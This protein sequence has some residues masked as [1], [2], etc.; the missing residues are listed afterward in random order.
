MLWAH[1]FIGRFDLTVPL[2]TV[3]VGAAAVVAASFGLIYLVP[4]RPEKPEQPGPRLPRWVVMALQAIALL[5]LAFLVVVGLL[6]RQTTVLNAATILFWVVTIPLLPIA[7]CLVGG[8]YQVANPFALLAR[9]LTGGA[10]ARRDPDPRVARWGYWPAV[11]QMF[12]LVFFELALRPVPNSPAALGVLVI[13]YTG[14]QVAMGVLMGEA[15]FA[16]G[17]VFSAITALASTIAPVAIARDDEGWVRLKVGFR[18]ARFLPPG[19]GREALI[20]LWL[21][22]VL[23]DGVRVTPIWTAVTGATKDFVEAGFSVLGV[24]V[25]QLA[26]DTAEIL[27]T[28]LAFSIFFWVFAY[29]AATL[30]QRSPRELA[31]VVSPSLIPIA[32][33]YLL[34]HNLTQIIVVAPLMITARDV[35]DVTGQQFRDLYQQALSSVKPEIVWWIQVGAIVV[36]HVLAVIMAHARL[37]R[38]ERDSNR[39]MRADLGWLTAMLIYTWTSLWVLAQPITRQAG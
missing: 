19:P 35:A 22:G 29:V 36:G 11:V 7:H 30:S 27:F 20:T 3:L 13:V 1:V 37:S 2:S 28:W 34:A 23:A 38:V 9:L 18:P 33:A 15:W 25:Y 10:S 8:V 26:L 31:P 39:A 5:Y 17:D 21:A 6:G 4:P 24:N 16:G 12:L 14:F 32:L